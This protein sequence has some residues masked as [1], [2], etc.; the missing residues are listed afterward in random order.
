MC[1][2]FALK[3][4]SWADIFQELGLKNAKGEENSPAHGFNKAPMQQVAIIKQG[5]TGLEGVNA[6]WSL[7][8]RFFHDALETK[9]FTTINAKAEEV[10]EKRSYRDAVRSQ[11]CVVLADCFYEWRR[12]SKT[13]KQP[14]AIGRKDGGLLVFAGA[15]TWWEG[16]WKEQPYSS[17]TAT[18][19][20][21]AANPFM[22]QIH[23]RMPV[24]LEHEK[25]KEW[26]S[27]D[28]QDAIKLAEPYPGQL[29]KA[30][31]VDRMVGNV[32]N[33]GPELITQT[34]EELVG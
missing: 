14:F 9:K 30:W 13:E 19:L 12:I 20:T 15:W 34:G 21:T 17:Y 6:L 23:S 28:I 8:P 7:I 5:E 26:M 4:R 3:E 29:M 22:E 33:Q 31:P 25:I 18:I 24:I 27:A 10:L 32:R 11:R 1:G 16:T 2:R